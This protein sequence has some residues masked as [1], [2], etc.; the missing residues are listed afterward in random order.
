MIRLEHVLKRKK[1]TLP[2]IKLQVLT[3]RNNKIGNIGAETIGSFLKTNNTLKY[4]DL[5]FNLF[6]DGALESISGALRINQ[7]LRFLGILGNEFKNRGILALSNALE[8]KYDELNSTLMILR[9]GDIACDDHI[10]NRFILEGVVSAKELRYLYFT[11]KQ[12]YNHNVIDSV[13]H[14][15][16]SDYIS[17]NKDYDNYMENIRFINESDFRKKN[18]TKSNKIPKIVQ[19]TQNYQTGYDNDNLLVLFD[20]IILAR[21]L[22]EAG[23]KYEKLPAKHGEDIIENVLK[24]SDKMINFE[25]LI[26]WFEQIFDP[27]TILDRFQL[28]AFHLF[29]LHKSIT[30]LEYWLKLGININWRTSIAHKEFP[31][32]TALH[33]AVANRKLDMI[34]FLVEQGIRVNEKDLN[35]NTAVHIAAAGG[36]IEIVEYFYS[37]NANF[38][39]P[40]KRSLIPMHSSIMGDNIDTFKLW[41]RA[42]EEQIDLSK[43]EENEMKIYI[44]N[45]SLAVRT[46]N[47]LTPLMLSVINNWEKIFYYLLKC[48]MDLNEQDEKGYTALHHAISLNDIHKARML[49]QFGADTKIRTYKFLTPYDL[50]TSKQLK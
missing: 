9:V 31:G 30:S 35:G 5:S 10:F 36:F 37:I 15:K 38:I 47:R 1:L 29:A 44:R 22:E 20:D 19:A 12:Y 39:M 17:D 2:V 3:L 28:S 43:L 49:I 45:P 48:D 46:K 40:N 11:S 24:D 8:Y 27:D 6:E 33:I 34:K 14:D 18:K 25:W 32:S 4:L 21:S 42:A 41:K 26:F 50:A 13:N 16:I 23:S 7:C